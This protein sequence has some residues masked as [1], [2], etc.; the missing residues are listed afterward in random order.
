MYVCVNCTTCADTK[1]KSMTDCLQSHLPLFL[2]GYVSGSAIEIAPSFLSQHPLQ[3]FAAIVMFQ[4][5]TELHNGYSEL[6]G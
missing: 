1:K 3:C 6:R 5:N 2:K 4:T